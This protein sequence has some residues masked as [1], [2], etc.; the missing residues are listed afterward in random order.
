[1]VI[2]FNHIYNIDCMIGMRLMKEQGIVADWCITDPPYGI[3]EDGAKNHSRGKLASATKFKPKSWDK[4]LNRRYIGFELD[5]DYFE[6]GVNR[7]NSENSQL[8]FTNFNY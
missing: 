7:L 1:M 8:E 4:K 5:N 2:E 3:G 6:L